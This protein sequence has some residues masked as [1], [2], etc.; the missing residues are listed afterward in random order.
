MAN[1]LVVFSLI[2]ASCL[3]AILVKA[4]ARPQ[5]ASGKAGDTDRAAILA[6]MTAQQ[7]DWNRG[8]IRG[9]MD[10][11]WNSSELTF[12]GTRG[13]TRGWQPVLA[14]YEKNYT[15]KAAMGTLGFSELEIRQLGPDAALV[16]GRWHLQR[17]AG[18]VGGI[19]TLVFQKFPEGWRIIHDHT[20]QSPPETK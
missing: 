12:A 1:K 19:F 8:N 20:T 15:D 13:F 16:L 9:F 10:G 6:V 4:S 3:G 2:L 5:P 18:D 14:R 17:Q 11:Y 7:S